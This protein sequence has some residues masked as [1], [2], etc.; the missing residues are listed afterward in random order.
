MLPFSLLLP[1]ILTAPADGRTFALTYAVEIAGLAPGQ[2]TRI[3]V[4]VPPTNDEQTIETLER[5]A[6][7]RSRLTRDPE[8]G[9]GIWYVESPADASGMLRLTARYRVVR[10]AVTPDNA[11]GGNTARMLRPDRLVPLDGRPL[12]LLAGR[13]LPAG[14]RA[15]A[16]A[17]FDLVFDH[18]RYGKDI[19]GWG[20]GDAVWAC[21]SRT[22]NCTDF[23]SLF[24][25][26]ARSR[27][28]PARFEIGFGLPLGRGKG[29]IGGYHCWAKVW[30]DGQ[31]LPL[32]ISEPDKLGSDRDGYFGKLPPNRV[33]FSV[34]R[35]VPLEPRPA[36]GPVNFFIHPIVE[37][38]GKPHPAAKVK[39]TITFA[40][41]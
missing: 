9:N 34:G 7:G 6:P 5:S 35:D 8:Y 36:G 16:R 11:V 22:G 17:L 3:W 4:P 19:E 38:G 20:R 1:L 27:G 40:D 37:A 25:S 10:R 29:E 21:D 23:H 31:W 14:D 12:T 32:D 39:S 30:A 28:L 13:T 24:M 2:T 41:E 18:M 33:L 26:L 15:K